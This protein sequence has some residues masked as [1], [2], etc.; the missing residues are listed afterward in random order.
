MAFRSGKCT[1]VNW[2]SFDI[3]CHLSLPLC[4]LAGVNYKFIQLVDLKKDYMWVSQQAIKQENIYTE[5][6]LKLTHINFVILNSYIKVIYLRFIKKL[7]F[8][9]LKI[10]AEKSTSTCFSYFRAIHVQRY[11]PWSEWRYKCVTRGGDEEGLHCRFPEIGKKCPNFGKKCPDC[12]HLSYNFSIQVQFLK[13]FRRKN[14]RFIPV[15]PLFLVLQ[16]EVPL[17]RENTPALKTSW[18]RA[19]VISH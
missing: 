2:T 1:S 9:L 11:W 6:Q 19:C 10:S 15:G 16:I 13:V 18:L 3:S 4:E 14:W 5:G 17:F 7:I 12:R 8:R